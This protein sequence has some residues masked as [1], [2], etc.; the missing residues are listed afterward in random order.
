MVDKLYL[1]TSSTSWIF[2]TAEAFPYS[3]KNTKLKSLKS[4]KRSEMQKQRSYLV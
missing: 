1:P 2:Y 4:S 3:Q